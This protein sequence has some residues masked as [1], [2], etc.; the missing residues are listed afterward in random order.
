MRGGLLLILRVGIVALRSGLERQQP[1]ELPGDAADLLAQT[2]V[3]E[4]SADR[5]AELSAELAGEVAEESLRGELAA[6][7]L[8]LILRIGIVALRSRLERQQPAE[9][10]GDAA[11]LL[12]E[13]TVAEASADPSADR[14]GDLA[15]GVTEE[16]LRREL[17]R[18]LLLLVLRVGIVPLWSCF[19]RQQPAELSG[20]AADLLAQ[21]AVAESSADPSAGRAGKLTD[22]VTDESLRRE[23]RGGLLLVL[24]V[25]VIPLRSCFERQQAAELS[26]DAADLL[27][28]AAVAETSADPSADR[29][30]D[31]ADGVTEESLRRELRGG[32]LLILR[33]G[34]VA[35]RSGLE[36]QQPAE[37]PGDAAD[38][39]AEPL[40]AKATADPSAERAA[41]LAECIADSA[42]RCELLA[43]QQSWRR[44][45]WLIS[46]EL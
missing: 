20:D 4:A 5:A 41:E 17:R 19:E 40:I 16:S 22:G 11:D 27:A 35:L 45:A 21:T 1:A 39:L 13:A 34:I 31:L 8:L 3:T 2:A 18:R 26:G 14:T 29:T 7:I 33:V 37:L 44:R 42:L 10:S 43:G 6:G 38:L 28:E 9:L 12:A 30:G 25:G 24:R 23:L 32:L 15:D 46:V 36:R